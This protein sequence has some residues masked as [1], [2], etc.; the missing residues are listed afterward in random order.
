MIEETKSTAPQDAP[1]R[2]V[3]ALLLGAGGVAAAFGAASC[4]AL[5]VL[6]GSL[7][8]GSAWLATVAWL[9]APHRLTLSAVAVMGLAAG[10]LLFWRG[11]RMTACGTGLAEARQRPP[12]WRP[13]YRWARF[14]SCSDGSTREPAGDLEINTHLP[15]LRHRQNRSYANRRLSVLL[16]LYRLR[17]IAAPKVRQ[18]LCV[19]LLRLGPLSASPRK[20][21]CGKRN[22]R[23]AQA[24]NTPG[25]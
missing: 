8:L 25:A 6:L 19:L 16:R 20:R 10:G 22:I 18:L 17:C 3:G 4:C 23:A 9:A 14:W 24:M 15:A 12:P 13:F 2:N 11:R 7:G 1:T 5:P 21:G